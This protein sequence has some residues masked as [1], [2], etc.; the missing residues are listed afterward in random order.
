MTDFFMYLEDSALV[1]NVLSFI[2]LGMMGVLVR[3]IIKAAGDVMVGN[4]A[5]QEQMSIYERMNKVEEIVYLNSVLYKN[6]VVNSSL[7]A[8]AKTKALEDFAAIEA[9][10]QAYL[11]GLEPVEETAADATETAAINPVN[12]A[13][14]AGVAT[15]VTAVVKDIAEA[16]PT[17]LDTI[18]DKIDL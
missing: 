3:A 5:L 18:K 6:A 8:T 12:A 2:A 11:E 13:I 17:V 10:H 14:T 16:A 15:A 4:A 1:A 7:D 9:A